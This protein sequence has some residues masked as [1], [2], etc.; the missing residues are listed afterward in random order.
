VT[1]QITVLR[2][3]RGPTVRTRIAGTL[4]SRS[5]RRLIAIVV[6][7]VAAVAIAAF[8][9]RGTLG[10]ARESTHIGGALARAIGPA[11]VAAAYGYP[12][13]CLRI[14]IALGDPTF[15]R[16][17][18]DHAMQC[19]L[20]TGYPTTIF[21]RVRGAWAPVLDAVAYS[22]PVRSLPLAVQDELAV[23]PSGR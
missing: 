21:H 15:A 16:A 11:G 19:G 3:P 5:G 14:T 22:C 10:R 9:T 7:V 23:C 12:L 6:A 20:Y 1:V 13:H 17:D 18:F 2:A 8:I 4:F